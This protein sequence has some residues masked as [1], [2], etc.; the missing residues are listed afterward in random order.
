MRLKT[1][2]KAS[3]S[4]ATLVFN[5]YQEYINN[6][7]P[8]DPA[9]YVIRAHPRTAVKI[10]RYLETSVIYKADV[11]QTTTTPWG[12]QLKHDKRL[13]EGI[14]VFGPE[15]IEILWTEENRI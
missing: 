6:H 15:T 7:Y 2:E 10:S 3:K 1:N 14:V 12:F 9:I 4:L 5:A 11:S 8:E 13:A